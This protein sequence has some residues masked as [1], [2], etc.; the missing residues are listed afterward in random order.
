[1]LASLATFFYFYSRCFRLQGQLADV[2]R[3]LA[4]QNA[5]RGGEADL[6]G[7]PIP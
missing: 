6:D 7:S 1:M 2:V 5:R 3:H 4:I